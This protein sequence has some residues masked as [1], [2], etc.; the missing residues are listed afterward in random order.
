MKMS[1][2]QRASFL[3]IFLLV[4]AFILPESVRAQ[5]PAQPIP[6]GFFLI[7]EAPGVRMYQKNYPGGS[8]DYI[9]QVNLNQGA[10]ILVMHGDVRE[11]RPGKGAYGGDDP[12]IQSRSLKNYWEQLTANNAQAFCVTNGQFFYMPESPTR[13]PFPL[14]VD[15]VILSDG[16]GINEFPDQKLM[17][18]LW[19]NRADITSLTQESLYSSD[20]P[21]II[22]GLTQTAKKRIDRYVGRTFVGVDDQ[23]IDGRYETVFIFNSSLA[24]QADAAGVLES[25]GADKVMMLDG[26][27]ST[28]LSCRGKSFIFSERLIPQAIGVIASQGLPT[29]EAVQ[30]EPVT[31]PQPPALSMLGG[32]EISS[33]TMEQ[34]ITGTDQQLQIAPEQQA[35]LAAV[36]APP[37]AG[38]TAQQSMPM[39]LSD[40]LYVPLMM[41]PVLAMIL[42][43]INKI[44]MAS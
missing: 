3:I 1:A 10:Q 26:G 41:S 40:V 4:F 29:V 21:N 25:F 23:D 6:E 17:L 28:Q 9:Q 31:T 18:E 35:A 20:A 13:L 33:E 15:G 34:S 37:A 42:F 16:Y 24:R 11:N 2:A 27:G 8:P 30:A 7:D 38:T 14:K 43:F 19:G 32:P 44:R 22:A 5:A 36:E 39:R 12:R